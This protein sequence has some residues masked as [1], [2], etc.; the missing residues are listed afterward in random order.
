MG[1]SSFPFRDSGRNRGDDLAGNRRDDMAGNR[2]ED[3]GS[4]RRDE[5]GANRR[6]EL[7]SNRRDDGSNRREARVERRPRTEDGAPLSLSSLAADLES[8]LRVLGA[9]DV[10]ELQIE[11]GD[12]KLTIRRGG[13]SAPVAAAPAAVSLVQPLPLGGPG[14][15]WGPETLIAGELRPGAGPSPAGPAPLPAS[16]AHPA[17]PMLGEREHMLTAPMV[18]TFYAAP[19]P[20]DPP[21]V[22]EGDLVESGQ[23]IGIIEAMKIM[24]EIEAEVTGR[25]SR[26]LV[27]DGQGV[28]YG[29]PLLVIEEAEA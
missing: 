2:R 22:V 26:I 13:A 29:Q 7:G 27:R 9:S 1:R 3:L 11:R 10:T 24:N 28:E 25:V 5:S 17:A 16:G 18:G 8:L 23:T 4:N 21:F 15:P 6:E 12:L 19:S 14:A 20:K